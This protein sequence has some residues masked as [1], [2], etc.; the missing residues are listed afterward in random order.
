MDIGLGSLET[1][2]KKSE[3]RGKEK[4]KNMKLLKKG[5]K[6]SSAN[7]GE[8]PLIGRLSFLR[9]HRR[10]GADPGFITVWRRGKGQVAI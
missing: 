5:T 9:T 1:R 7:V 8:I 6:R 10:L 2:R 3:E 4:K